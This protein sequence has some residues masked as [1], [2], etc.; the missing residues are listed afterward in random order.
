MNRSVIGAIAVSALVVAAVLA[1]NAAYQEREYRRL[2]AVG[3][4]ALSRDQTFVAIEAFSGAVALKRDSM[5]AYL[6]RGQ[7]YSRRRELDSALRDLREAVRLDPT[8][9]QPLELLGDV[10][11]EM[12][13]YER[14][15]ELY[16]RFVTLDDRAP[17]VLYKLALTYYRDGQVPAAIEPLR[18]AVA[19][20][21]RLAEA[22]YLLGMCLRERRTYED[23]IRALTQAIEINPGLSAAREELGDLYLSRGRV[24]EGLEQFEALA[25]LEP[26]RV[27]RQVGLS[28]AYARVGRSEA[29]IA[30][31]G[32]AAERHPDEP[33]VL[34][35]L[36][37]VWL[38]SAER[39]QNPAALAKAM[40]ALQQAVRTG[41]PSTDTLALYGRAL[42]L[43]GNIQAAEQILQQATARLPVDPR[44]LLDLAGAAERLGHL[45]VQRQALVQYVSLAGDDGAPG[46]RSARIAELAL[47]MN[48]AA[49]A[50]AWAQR[51]ITLGNADTLPL[52]L[53]ADAQV[54]LKDYRAARQTVTRALGRDPGN[55]SLLRLQRRIPARDDEPVLD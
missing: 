40:E 11:A 12:Q 21:P 49:S 45:S 9:P 20:D 4:E 13:R 38:E 16:R 42:L 19:I 14:A 26:S 41:E 27:E 10:N 39:Q 17:R 51:S 55:A 34:A 44:A 50:A 28:L 36:G 6:K 2:I 22:H 37:R 8:A 29:A 23:A 1:W 54:R 43:A 31:L 35:S 47:R 33:L 30:A 53:L 52:T 48:D 32:R 25:A 5:L 18:Q 24:R 15:A 7:T 3:D 46:A